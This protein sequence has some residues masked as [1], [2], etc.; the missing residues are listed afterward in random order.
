MVYSSCYMH[1]RGDSETTNILALHC[2]YILYVLRAAVLD[3]TQ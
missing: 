1:V 3:G 2:C